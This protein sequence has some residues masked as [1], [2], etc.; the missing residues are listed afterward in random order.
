MSSSMQATFSANACES[1]SETQKSCSCSSSIYACMFPP[2]MS[3][4]VCS[5]EVKKACMK[6]TYEIMAE[7][8][9]RMPLI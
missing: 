3:T 5:D 2:P 8:A 9:Y 6:E 4:T 7:A 1:F